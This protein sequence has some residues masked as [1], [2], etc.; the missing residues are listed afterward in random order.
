MLSL[1]FTLLTLVVYKFLQCLLHHVFSLYL[2][3]LLFQWF[4]HFCQFFL[5]LTFFLRL[6]VLSTQTFLSLL[7]LFFF[8]EFLLFSF[9]CFLCF[10]KKYDG[11][12]NFF[13]C[14]IEHLLLIWELYIS[15][16]KGSSFCVLPHCV[17]SPPEWPLHAGLA[18]RPFQVQDFTVS[19]LKLL[20]QGL[21][22]QFKAPELFLSPWADLVL[23]L[24]LG[25]ALFWFQQRCQLADLLF[26]WSSFII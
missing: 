9:K 23:L 6:L 16:L 1:P 25:G 22:F 5:C 12:F 19:L 18:D 21:R 4:L 8:F 26:V 14:F 10:L 17:A 3:F 11:C 15:F 20:C 2:F 13:F 7:Q 24:A